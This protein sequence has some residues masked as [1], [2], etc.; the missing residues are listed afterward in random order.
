MK[1]WSLLLVGISLLVGCGEKKVDS[2]SDESLKISISTIKESL[3]EQKK[4]EFEKAVKVIA[5]SGVTNLFQAAANAEGLQQKMKE[6]LNGK[7]ADEIIAASNDILAAR[8]VKE[9]EQAAKEIE[10]I[11]TD[12]LA[13]EKKKLDA[14]KVKDDLKK[15]SVLRSRFYYQKS[16]YREEAVIELTVK[17]NT[18]YAVS[19]VYFDGVLAS[20]GRSVPWVSDSFNHS[21]AGGIEP[22][23]EVTW[24]LTPNRFGTWG[25]APKNRDD[26]LLTVSVNRIDGADKKAIFNSAV[27]KS[28]ERKLVKLNK[29]LKKLTNILKS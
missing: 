11:K 27:S 4:E 18:E 25:K 12:I 14:E 15:F 2:T 22:G 19:R 16:S 9:R 20:Q 5:F 23:E 29:R 24:K 3:T 8:K 7:T 26:M 10:E 21:I 6:K 17:N 13:L 28:N 1:N